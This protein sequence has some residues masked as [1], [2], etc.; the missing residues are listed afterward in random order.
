MSGLLQFA[1]MK[2][3][4]PRWDGLR[5]TVTALL[6]VVAVVLIALSA[7]E[8]LFRSVGIGAGCVAKLFLFLDS[9]RIEKQRLNEEIERCRLAFR[10]K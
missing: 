4:R 7:N 2:R 8:N 5:L 10:P 6:P 3:R 1:G 9:K